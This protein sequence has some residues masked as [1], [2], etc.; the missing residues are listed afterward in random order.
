VDF[1]KSIKKY[2]PKAWV[3]NLTN[4]MTVL[5]QVLCEQGCKAVGLCHELYGLW[6]WLRERYHCG[7][8][9]ICLDVAGLNHFGFIL[10][11]R[12]KDRDCFEHFKKLAADPLNHMLKPNVNLTHAETHGVFV[13]MCEYFRRTGFQLYPGDRHTSEFFSN[14]LT[15]ETGY[16]KVYNIK[17]TTIKD[18]YRWLSKARKH[19][20][21]L[22]M[23]PETIGLEPSREAMSSLI[24]SLLTGKPI[25]EV[26]N[27][28]NV[29]QIENLPRG[30]VVETM[31]TVTTNKISPHAVG[32]LPDE[33][34][35]LLTPHAIRFN[36]TIRAGLTGDRQLALQ[37]LGSDPLVRD[38]STAGELLDKMIKANKKFLPQ[39]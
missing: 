1:A 28:P 9:D 25:V 12:Y 26:V 38:W 29:G 14:V 21:D 23:H 13:F 18:R 8:E 34:A 39:F 15:K 20:W 3:F 7:W 31:A 36:M 24:V 35:V 2:C 4:P 6:G 10:S 32:A 5:T 33:M 17:L 11:A 22:T 37:A 30:V 27:L 16:G 19:T